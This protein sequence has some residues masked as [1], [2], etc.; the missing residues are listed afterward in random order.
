MS[1][2]PDCTQSEETEQP[3]HLRLGSK[4]GRIYS[5]GLL[6]LLVKADCPVLRGRVSLAPLNGWCIK[7]FA[8]TIQSVATN[9]IPSC[10]I[11]RPSHKW[12]K[13]GNGS[14]NMTIWELKKHTPTF[15]NVTEETGLLRHWILRGREWEKHSRPTAMSSS[16]VKSE[17]PAV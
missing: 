10:K 11:Y 17:G 12:A 15:P 14:G 3:L 9:Y 7:G 5:N 8:A 4:P 13:I 1:G 16:L 2:I 6:I